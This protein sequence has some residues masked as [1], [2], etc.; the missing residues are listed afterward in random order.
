MLYLLKELNVE[1]KP[2]II[3]SF[4]KYKEENKSKA[5]ITS[6]WRHTKYH[7]VPLHLDSTYPIIPENY[8]FVPIEVISRSGKPFKM[9]RLQGTV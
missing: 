7:S 8:S 6:S 9:L 4:N 5:R 3:I 1:S 2:I